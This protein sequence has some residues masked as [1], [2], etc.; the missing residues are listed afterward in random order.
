[1]E[2]NEIVGEIREIEEIKDMIRHVHA[3]VENMRRDVAVLMHK[4][5]GVAFLHEVTRRDVEEAINSF[6]VNLDEMYSPIDKKDREEWRKH[7]K[8]EILDIQL[9]EM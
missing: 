4:V 7:L 8:S 6:D 3:D 1:M 9:R 2:E 5:D